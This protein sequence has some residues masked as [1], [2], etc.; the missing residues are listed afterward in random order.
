MKGVQPGPGRS[1]EET[2]IAMGEGNPGPPP[3]RRPGVEPAVTRREPPGNGTATAAGPGAGPGAGA[4]GWIIETVVSPF[5]CL[6]QDAL[7]F[8]TQSHLWLA[9][10]ESQASRLARAA[11]VL[12]LAGAEALVHQAAVELGR[13]D[14]ASLLAD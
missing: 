6:Y 12:Y 9:R 3:A 10:S 13:P 7:H 1:R 14:L 8:H 11:L 5:R 2:R 4:S